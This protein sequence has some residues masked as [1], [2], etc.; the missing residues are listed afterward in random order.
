[1]DNKD[2]LQQITEQKV[3][4]QVK[5]ETQTV[6]LAYHVVCMAREDR[7][8]KRQRNTYLV[9]IVVLLITFTFFCIFHDCA[10]Y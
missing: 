7:K 6:Q 8:Q 9:I 10:S 4:E 2:S 1:M 5:Y 3:A